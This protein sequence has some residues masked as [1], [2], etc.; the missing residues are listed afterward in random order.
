MFASLTLSPSQKK[1][2]QHIKGEIRNLTCRKNCALPKEIV[3]NKLNEVV[4]GWVNYF[5]YSN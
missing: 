4:R 3:V 5:Y 2:E 1:A